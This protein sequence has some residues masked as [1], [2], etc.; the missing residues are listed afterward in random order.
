[1]VGKAPSYYVKKRLLKNVPA[2]G[3]AI[4]IS[5]AVIVALLGYVIMPD[6]TPYA[7]DSITEIKKQAPGFKVSLLRIRINMELEKR[8]FFHEIFEGRPSN[9]IS[10]PIEK[11]EILDSCK[12]RIARFGGR[13]DHYSYEVYPLVDVAYSLYES[14]S[15]KLN[16][17]KRKWQCDGKY[18]KYL[19]R[20]EQIQKVLKSEVL[21]LVIEKH[22]L[23]KTYVL[24]T[25]GNGRDV[26]SKLI[27]GARISLTIGIIA[28]LIS[29]V[30]GIGMGAMAGFFKGK[31]DQLIMWIMTVIW[32]IPRIMLV[33][34]IGLAL[35][36]SEVWVAFVAVGLTMWVEVARIVRGKIMEI[37]ENLYVEAARAL[38]FSNIRIIIKHILPNLIGPLIVILTANFADA[39]L[40]EAGLSFLGLSVQPPMPSWGQMVQ[41]GY[42]LITSPG[43]WHLIL[44]PG[45]CISLLVMSFNLLGNG[46]RDAFDPKGT[47][48]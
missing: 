13:K 25:D 48:E 8:N 11:Y 37:R 4:I 30:V 29:L 34:A 2:V 41:E 17:N 33:I 38:G 10:R 19:D 1:M 39:I 16:S 12:I 23:E 46:L 20:N 5:L 42:S 18:I 36:S 14:S 28:V 47:M 6:N 32:S 31:I 7:N 22:I 9:F 45:L 3:G 35:H 27:F 15:S 26:L 43:C 40:I 24:G 44:F 21:E